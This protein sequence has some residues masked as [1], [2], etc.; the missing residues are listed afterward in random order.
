MKTMIASL[1]LFAACFAN[2]EV[3]KPE[4][5]NYRT[6]GETKI[7]GADY[8]Y[9]VTDMGWSLHASYKPTVNIK[10]EKLFVL[11]YKSSDTIPADQQ[12]AI[13]ET[14]IADAQAKCLELGQME[15][16]TQKAP[17]EKYYQTSLA[18]EIERVSEPSNGRKLELTANCRVTVRVTE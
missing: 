4:L 12:I 1:I 3:V 10:S 17:Y 8:K 16:P 18:T 11:E 7:E 9:Y 5:T 13:R 6:R 14:V 2:A 15:Y